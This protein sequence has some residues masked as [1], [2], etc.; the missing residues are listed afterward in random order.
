MKAAWA[1]VLAVRTALS[2]ASSRLSPQVG[3]AEE[4]L[5][6]DY[7]SQVS[8]QLSCPRHVFQGVEERG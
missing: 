3:E 8:L 6:A 4:R 7:D 5:G 2:M 1:R